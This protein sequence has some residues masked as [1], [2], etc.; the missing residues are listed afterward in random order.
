M[1]IPDLINGVFELFGGFF[2]YL[3]VK[4]L[5][6]DKKVRGVSFIHVGFFAAWGFWNLYYYPHLNQI[7]SFIGGI[8][9]VIMNTLYLIQLIYYSLKETTLI[10][11][12]KHG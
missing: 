1:N 2:I 12:E 5:F 8:F 9:I 4:K 3:S 7:A 11:E 6:N 10:K